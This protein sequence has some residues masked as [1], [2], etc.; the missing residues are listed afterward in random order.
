MK[1]AAPEPA[2]IVTLVMVL[3]P[4]PR[5]TPA[6]D[7]DFR[8]TVRL[9]EVFTAL[10][11]A[12]SSCTVIVPDD[13]PAVNVLVAVVKPRW[14]AAAATT[15]SSWA[16]GVRSAVVVSAALM[17]GKPTAVS[18]YMKVTELW[19]PGIVMS[20]I[21]VAPL[22]NWPS[23]EL[24]VGSAVTPSPPAATALPYWSSNCTATEMDPPAV[25]VCTSAGMKAN[26]AAAAGLTV[27][28]WVAEVSPLAAA[29][30]VGVPATVSS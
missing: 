22:K 4:V 6:E 24:D 13:V 30:I 1:L 28:F 10:P 27:S 25:K 17:T 26:L 18:W 2:G 12:S 29:V 9:L 15:C 11:S 14:L 7:D 16:A 5:N 20:V 3:P 23:G 19:P 21:W 8:P